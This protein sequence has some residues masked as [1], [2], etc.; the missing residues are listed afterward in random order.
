M[1]SSVSVAGPLYR[2]SFESLKM[3]TSQ[4]G[5]TLQVFDCWLRKINLP[6]IQNIVD[7]CLELREIAIFGRKSCDI[8]CRIPQD[9]MEY[10]VNNLTSKIEK[11]DLG[12]QSNL[13]DLYFKTL[14]SRCTQLT[15]LCLAHTQIT[16]KS[17]TY[18]IKHLNSTLEKLGLTCCIQID[19]TAL[20][21]LKSMPRLKVL[22]FRHLKRNSQQVNELK[23]QLP[24]VEV[25]TTDE[26]PII[27]RSW[28]WDF[29]VTE[30][31]ENSQQNFPD[32]EAE[33]VHWENG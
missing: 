2:I 5:P 28:Q 11:I 6:T 16:N 29:N 23:M 13:E 18:I 8:E 32:P 26:D 33:F 25:N 4:N 30:L 3:I 21:E 17:V 14:V 7:N 9:A 12:Y 24:N 15:E 10:F 19:Y 22:S 20:F 27:A 1:R 31:F